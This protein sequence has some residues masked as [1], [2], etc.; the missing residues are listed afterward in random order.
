MRKIKTDESIWEYA[1]KENF[2]VIPITTHIRKDGALV[3]TDELAKEAAEKFP[4]LQKRWGYFIQNNVFSPTYRR[5]SINLIGVIE[6]EHYA[7]RPSEETVEQN[8][9]L[10]KEVCENNP[11]YVFYLR[12][13]IGGEEFEELNFRVLSD[14]RFILLE[15]EPNETQV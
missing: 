13:P 14:D 10:L 1:G 7:S 15:M 12:T 8:L 4:D 11:S 5:A 6:R 3:L 2:F 9:Y